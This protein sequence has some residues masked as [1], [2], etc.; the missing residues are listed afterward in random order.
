[1]TDQAGTSSGVAA[2]NRVR[3]KEAHYLR[4]AV[5]EV[6]DPQKL[7]PVTGVWVD[8]DDHGRC[9]Y[10]ASELESEQKPCGCAWCENVRTDFCDAHGC[11]RLSCTLRGLHRVGEPLDEDDDSDCDDPGCGL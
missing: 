2:P 8:I 10:L 11:L 1:M 3:V 6:Q 5:A 7:G 9:F 4:G